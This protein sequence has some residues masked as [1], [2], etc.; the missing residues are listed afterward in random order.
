[1]AK[2]RAGQGVN[3]LA[4]KP[5][6]Q[7]GGLLASEMANQLEANKLAELVKSV[8]Q[9][10]GLPGSAMPNQ[11]AELYKQAEL[12]KSMDQRDGLLARALRGPPD[13]FSNTGAE[14]LASV[15]KHKSSKQ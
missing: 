13:G 8:N 6:D 12:A 14:D 15:L 10:T 1:M 9:Q 7:K 5:V 4:K 11:L 2:E 3:K